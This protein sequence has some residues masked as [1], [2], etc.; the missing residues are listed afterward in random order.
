M[1]EN[2]M[3]TN[4]EM[5]ALSYNRLKY[6]GTRI[7]KTIIFYIANVLSSHSIIEWSLT[8]P[9]M[10]VL[11]SIQAWNHMKTNALCYV[12]ECLQVLLYS[13]SKYKKP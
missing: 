13:P 8:S 4:C 5:I 12:T 3:V 11:M 9:I 7:L 10:P 2:F 6:S 1:Y